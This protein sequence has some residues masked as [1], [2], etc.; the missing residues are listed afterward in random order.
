MA[1]QV[2]FDF[3]YLEIEADKTYIFR[4]TENIHFA[5]FLLELIKP[6][7]YPDVVA[8]I[9]KVYFDPEFD[10]IANS[11]AVEVVE[12]YKIPKASPS[13]MKKKVH[14]SYSR[15]SRRR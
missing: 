9:K 1:A 10:S 8:N 3:P 15:L 7:E 5:D 14:G 12:S 13:A 11:D 6:G 2:H 4:V